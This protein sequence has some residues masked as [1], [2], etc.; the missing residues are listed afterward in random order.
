MGGRKGT[1]YPSPYPYPYQ[2]QPFPV[3][4]P[5]PSTPKGTTKGTGNADA[6]L[7]PRDPPDALAHA[8]SECDLLVIGDR[9][10]RGARGLGHVGARIVYAVRS[11]VLVVRIPGTE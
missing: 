3:A 9:G 5:Q 1:V 2:Y 4:P 11:S 10:A 7:D 6:R 8:A